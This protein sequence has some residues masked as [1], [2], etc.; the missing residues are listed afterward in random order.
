MVRICYALIVGLAGLLNF[1]S[2]HPG[3]NV[4][5]EAAVRAAYLRN[6]PVQSR[7]LTHCTDE[8]RKRGIDDTNFARREA[9]V[10]QLRKQRGLDTGMNPPTVLFR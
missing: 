3:D 4:K 5:A 8:F 10:H 7:S 2:A 1:V 6:I 9:A